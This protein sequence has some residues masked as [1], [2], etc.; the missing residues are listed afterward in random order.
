MSLVS[1][2]LGQS[3]TLTP[4]WLMG[5]GALGSPGVQW[6]ICGVIAVVCLKRVLAS[7]LE[8]ELHGRAMLGAVVFELTAGG[9]QQLG[10]G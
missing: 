2:V 9:Q 5:L 8:L 6:S 10:S 3:V 7:G 1:S 4:V